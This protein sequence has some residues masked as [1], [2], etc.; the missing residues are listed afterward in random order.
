MTTLPTR[1]QLLDASEETRPDLLDALARAA[2]DGDSDAAAELAWAVLHFRLARAP[3]RQYLIG[4]A[5]VQAAEQATLVAI[6]F[7]I[8]SWRGEGRFTTWLWQ[9]ASNEAKMV[10]R[11]ERRHSDRAEVGEPIDHA[12]HFVARVSSMIADEAMVR[13]AIAKLVDNH[14]EALLLREE[15]GLPYDEIAERLGIPSGTA[16]T[17]V[18]RAR[19]ELA[20]RLTEAVRPPH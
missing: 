16:K 2:V 4:D 20:E 3:I 5:D 6:A 19:I 9:V 11:S 13:D 18:R 15:Q 8:G 10:I 17:W 12:E 7:R 1:R 14:R